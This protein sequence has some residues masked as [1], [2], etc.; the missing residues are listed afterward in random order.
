MEMFDRPLKHTE[1]FN[2]PNPYDLITIT[3]TFDDTE[4]KPPP[5]TYFPA[6]DPERLTPSLW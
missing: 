5:K 3:A 4:I 2:R 1:V 6:Y